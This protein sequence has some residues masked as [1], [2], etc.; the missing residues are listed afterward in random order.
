MIWD[1]AAFY[2]PGRDRPRPAGWSDAKRE[3]GAGTPGPPVPGGVVWTR[4]HPL[5]GHG[6]LTY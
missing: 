4:L 6:L 2:R 1:R 3:H 5:R